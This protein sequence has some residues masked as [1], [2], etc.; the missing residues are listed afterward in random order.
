M[1]STTL[2]PTK[3]HTVPGVVINDQQFLAALPGAQLFQIVVDP[4]ATENAKLVAEDPNLAAVR[5][6]RTEVQ[7]LFEGAKKRNVPQYASYIEAIHRGDTGLTPSIMLWS[8]ERLE[9]AAT[10]S[11]GAL[12]QIPYD[13]QL[14][15]ID[16]ET[17]L[18]ARFEAARKTP[19][20][21]GDR[22]AVMFCHGRTPEWA[23]QAFH[24]VNTFGVRPNAALAIGMD[25]R[26]PLTAVARDLESAIPF[27][28]DR[29]N[30]ASRQ[31][32]KR[33]TDVLT[34]TA[35]RGACV[36][37]A[38]GIAGVK[39]G[40]KPVYLEN[41]KVDRVRSAAIEWFGAVAQLLGPAIEDRERKVAGASP[42]F[43]A[44][45]A[46]GHELV[47]VDQGG[48]SRRIQELLDT[49]RAVKWEKGNHWVGIAGKMTPSGKFS[50]GG[51]KE[52]AYQ[53]YA[54]LSDSTDAGYAK[55]RRG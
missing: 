17:Q 3:G 4:Q 10:E 52:V 19:S 40:A 45:G 25:A 47:D 2:D 39:H 41:G 32:G 33:D 38:E 11:G 9:T 35:L 36:T 43:A 44:I 31:L 29:V 20:T 34:I 22:I 30:T 46:L 18:A 13:A 49:L 51:T 53:V 28:R 55:I 15:A 37:F 50:V 26:D 24:D 42:V 54:A 1:P 16:G 6:V 7:R 21:K 5:E 23:R 8:R 14:I 27:F 48:R 12:L